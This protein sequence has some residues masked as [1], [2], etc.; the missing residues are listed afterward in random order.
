MNVFSD[1][2]PRLLQENQRYL[3]QL[4]SLMQEATDEQSK[5]IVVSSCLTRYYSYQHLTVQLGTV[6]IYLILKYLFILTI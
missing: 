2:A 5:S 4:T 3:S 6:K 1:A